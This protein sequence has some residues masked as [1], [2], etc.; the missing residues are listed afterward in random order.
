MCT[1]EA[2]ALQLEIEPTPTA[3]RASTTLATVVPAVILKLHS[4]GTVTRTVTAHR[5]NRATELSNDSS[6]GSRRSSWRESGLRR[7]AGARL[8]ATV[9]QTRRASS[10]E[11][12]RNLR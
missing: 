4:T 2:R 10:R 12:G 6:T 3:R 8:R 11:K 1:A 9:A 7:R 5:L